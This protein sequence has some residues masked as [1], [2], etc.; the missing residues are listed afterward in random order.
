[1]EN[2]ITF[3]GVLSEGIGIGLKNAPSLLGA[4]ILWILTIWIPYINV[5]T[6]I[7][8]A[9]IPVA[10]SEGRVISPLFIFDKKYR[11]IMG[12]YFMLVGLMAI[13]IVPAM[14][15]LFV[16]AMVISMAWCLAIYI[17]IDKQVSPTQAIVQ[18]NKATLG[19]KWTIFGVQFLLGLAAGIFGS[20]LALIPYVGPVLN[21]CVIIVMMVA[22][23]GCN[24]VIYRKLV[25]EEA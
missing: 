10:L 19:Y 17:L 11:T 4:V 23:L 5:G 9:S 21:I 16:P 24:G 13:A 15:F 22:M 14:F 1:M 6:T 12:E 2:K 3:Q 18:S 20:V 7:A 25:K 8:I